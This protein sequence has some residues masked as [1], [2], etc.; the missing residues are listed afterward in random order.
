MTRPKQSKDRKAELD[1]AFEA[2]MMDGEVTVYSLGEYMDLKPRTVKNRLK[3]DGRFWIDGEKVGRKEPA[4]EVKRSVI[5]AIT[6]CCENAVIAAILHDSKH[7]KIA[8]IAAMTATI[9]SAKI[10]YI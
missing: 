3:E 6:S 4:A 5:F 1:T 9:C 2:C 10:A 8:E 7:C